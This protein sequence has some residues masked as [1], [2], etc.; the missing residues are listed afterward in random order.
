MKK[1]CIISGTR[2]EYGLFVPIMKEINKSKSLQLQL[3]VTTMHLS[4]EHGYTY[5]EIEK[6]GFHI[7]A[8]INNLVKPESTVLSYAALMKK[9]PIELEKLKPDTVLLLGDRFE[10]H[11]AATTCLLMNIAIAHIHGGEITEGAVDEQLRHS[12]TKM[13]HLHFTSTKE[14]KNRIMQ[15]GEQ[16]ENIHVSGAPG[17][18]NILSLQLKTKQELEDELQWNFGEK[19]ALFTFHPETLSTEST[20]S[21]IDSILNTIESTKL[22][23]LFTAANADTGGEIINQ[24]IKKFVANNKYKYKMVANLGMLNYFSAMK[25]IDAVIGNSSSG[26]IE[27]ASYKKPVIDIGNRQ[28]GRLTSGNVIQCSIAGFAAALEKAQSTNFTSHCQTVIN[29]YGAGKAAKCII[30]A[31]TEQPVKIIKKFNDNPKEYMRS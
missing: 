9:L 22:N 15:M 17:I 26:I 10:T 4:K 14:Y 11:A 13:S 23:V 12:I 6:N 30:K 1:I 19:S 27:A 2:A 25:N 8:K 7:D 24:Q 21:Q 31:L 29:R 3:I 28:K 5:K 20:R 18:D 16:E